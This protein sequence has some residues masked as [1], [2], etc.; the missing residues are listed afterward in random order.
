[1]PTSFVLVGMIFLDFLIS[2]HEKLDPVE[3][4]FLLDEESQDQEDHDCRC[5]R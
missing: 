2:Y 4:H 5:H 1:M 3:E